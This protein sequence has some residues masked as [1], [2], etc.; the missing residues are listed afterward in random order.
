MAQR[1]A[2]IPVLSCCREKIWD[3]VTLNSD[4]CMFFLSSTYGID[5]VLGAGTSSELQT[6]RNTVDQVLRTKL[7]GN[8]NAQLCLRILRLA[9]EVGTGRTTIASA[10]RVGESYSSDLWRTFVAQRGPVGQIC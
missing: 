7:T 2:S 8:S 5:H 10:N 6:L 9:R 3:S 4:R 1:L